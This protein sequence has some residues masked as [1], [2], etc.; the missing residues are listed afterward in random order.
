METPFARTHGKD[1]Q[2]PTPNS[3]E[4]WHSPSPSITPLGRILRLAASVARVSN[5]SAASCHSLS[6][7]G[8]QR[9]EAFINAATELQ[10][11]GSGILSTEPPTPSSVPASPAL[12]PPNVDPT[13]VASA[14]PV[15]APIALAPPAVAPVLAA[16]VSAGQAIVAL[17]RALPVTA[18]PAPF[19]F[20]RLPRRIELDMQNVCTPAI[21]AR[22]LIGHA[23]GLPPRGPSPRVLP[24]TTNGNGYWLSASRAQIHGGHCRMT[25]LGFPR[26]ATRAVNGQGPTAIRRMAQLLHR[27]A[28]RAWGTMAQQR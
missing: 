20:P 11:L 28:I 25:P 16:P 19:V 21:A 3:D 5:A 18:D 2:C 26:M 4:E 27:L 13:A 24:A 6:P 8:Q 12:A 7:I 1:E 17:A 23:G 15:V 10:A 14:A 9:L 22:S